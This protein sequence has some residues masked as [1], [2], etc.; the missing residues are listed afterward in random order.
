MY[1]VKIV[2]K[3]KMVVPHQDADKYA[4]RIPLGSLRPCG[5]QLLTRCYWQ[6][7]LGAWL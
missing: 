2:S 4:K 7:L 1:S 5:E 6:D 3:K